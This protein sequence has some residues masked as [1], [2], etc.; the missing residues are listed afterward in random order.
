[1]KWKITIFEDK[2]GN[3][4]SVVDGNINLYKLIGFYTM[5][6]EYLKKQ[7]IEGITNG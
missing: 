1:M 6:L 2:E 5:E 4:K 3:I 7:A